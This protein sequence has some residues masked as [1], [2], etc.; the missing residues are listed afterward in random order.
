MGPFRWKVVEQYFTVVLFG[1]QFYPNLENVSSLDL[2]LSRVKGL[3]LMTPWDILFFQF[4]L[5]CNF[6]K[7][8]MKFGLGRV[9][10][11]ARVK[12]GRNILNGKILVLTKCLIISFLAK[13]IFLV[14]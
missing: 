2:A 10:R 14:L 11:S 8:V 9:V 6:E 1:F 5:V 4:Y 13:I 12:T 7:F 3:S